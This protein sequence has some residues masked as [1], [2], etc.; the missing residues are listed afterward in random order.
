MVAASLA[1]GLALRLF[2]VCR[3]AHIEGDGLIYGNLAQ[4]LLQHGVYGFTDNAMGVRPTLI[5]LPGYPLFLAGCFAIF[6]VGKYFAVLLVQVVVDLWTCVLVAGV[7]RRIFGEQAGIAALWMGCMCPFM[8]TYTAAPLTEV[9]TLWTIALALYALAHWRT[10]GAGINRWLFVLAFALGFSLLLRPE[11]GLLAAAIVPAVLWISWSKFGQQGLVWTRAGLVVSLLTLMPLVPWTLRNLRTFHVF[12]PLAPRFANDAGERVPIGFQRWFRTWGVDFASTDEVYWL[13]DGDEISIGNLP[14]RAFDSEEQYATTD[15]LLTEYNETTT[16]SPEFDTRFAA[17]ADE[18]IKADPLRYYVE[19]PVARVVN[20]T[21]RPRTDMLPWP[22]RWWRLQEHPWTTVGVS[23][24]AL[25][26]LAY[27][28]FA[29]VT[30]LRQ[31]R[32]AAWQPVIWAL[33]AT[34]GLRLALLLTI[35]N[36]EPRYTLEFY[37]V[38]LVLGGASVAS[39]SRW[40]LRSVG[41]RSARS[42]SL[43]PSLPE[44]SASRLD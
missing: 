19:L 3:Y 5:R 8:A 14:K 43:V 6:G 41:R 12:Q 7:S 39:L 2:F 18:R 35:D 4:N 36:S 22:L 17:I 13:Y 26:N 9:L 38:L 33:V 44:G 34:V 40:L 25:L 16:A 20:M 11:Q 30:L 23:G 37:P 21:L 42:S 24:F 31:E 32:W 15:A 28:F 10:S 29:V 1:F 27:M